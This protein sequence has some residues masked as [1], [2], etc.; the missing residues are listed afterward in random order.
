MRW[1][2]PGVRALVTGASSGIGAATARALA[3]TGTSLLLTGRDPDRL[4]TVAAAT[5]GTAVPADLRRAAD[6]DRLCAAATGVDLVVLNAGRGWAGPLGAMSAEQLR[7]IVEVDLVAPLELT[8]RLLPAMVD[9]GTGAVVLVSSIAG[10]VGVGGEAVYSAA[11]AGLGGFADS[12][13]Q[14]VAGS[15]VRVSVVVPGVVDT[16]FFTRRGRPYDRSRPRPVPVER[17]A[18]AV[19]GAAAS[20]RA[21]TYVPGW[22]A[23]PARLHGAVPGLYARLARAFG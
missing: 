17:A 14:E 12:L 1:P 19:L 4:G 6:L 10:V 2:G 11:K 9:R 21:L 8:R 7:D 13:R 15:G 5:G 3:A 20:G 22:L 16:P 23:V 18:A